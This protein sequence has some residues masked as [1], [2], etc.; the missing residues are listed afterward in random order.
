MGDTNPVTRMVAGFMFNQHGN[1]VVL[2]RKTKPEW[3]A[4]KLNAVGGKIEGDESAYAAMV[5]EFREETGVSTYESS[6]RP[7]VVLKGG[8]FEVT[9]FCTFVGFDQ[10]RPGFVGDAGE[11]IEVHYAHDFFMFS[12]ISNLR[13]LI[14]LCLDNDIVQTPLVVY[15]K[16]CFTRTDAGPWPPEHEQPCGATDCPTC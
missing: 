15:D 8:D 1:K 14:P 5:R 6:W 7:V 12:H 10:I 2:V 13:W 16:T 4:N 3:Q 9:F 11:T